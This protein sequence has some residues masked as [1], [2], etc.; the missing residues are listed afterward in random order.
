MAWE[1]KEALEYYKKQGAPSDQSALVSLFREVQGEFGS[2]PK[3]LLPELAVGLG[4]KESFLLALIRRQPR[5]RLADCHTLEL[6]A[7]SNCGKRAELAALAEKLC[8]GRADIQLK[9]VSCMR[10]C[11][12]GPNLR[13]DG[14]LY[15]KADETLLRQLLSEK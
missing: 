7:G 14:Q 6:C 5:L 3:H 1:L 2:I 11:G 4:V 15:N 10:L 8:A 12:K 9:F 13:W